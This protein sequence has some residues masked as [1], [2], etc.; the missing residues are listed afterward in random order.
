MNKIG[1]NLKL[2]NSFEV[3]VVL[4][5]VV[6][7]AIIGLILVSSLTPRQQTAVATSFEIFDMQEQIAKVGSALSFI[8]TTAN[9]FYN[10]FYLAFVQTVTLPDDFMATASDLASGFKLSVGGLFAQGR[11]AGASTSL[12]DQYHGD[13]DQIYYHSTPKTPAQQMPYEYVAPNLTQII[14]KV[15]LSRLWRE[16]L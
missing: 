8:N 4:M 11:V 2:L 5:I 7:F 3:C 10:Q 6:G 16:K 13:A 15:D 1:L 9:E 12:F 14:S